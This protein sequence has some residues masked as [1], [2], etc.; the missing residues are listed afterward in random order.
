[1][2]RVKCLESYNE[3]SSRLIKSTVI[4]L[5]AFVFVA[6]ISACTNL[7][8]SEKLKESPEN[9]QRPQ[10]VKTDLDQDEK[11]AKQTSLIEMAERTLV[12]FISL[13]P[14]LQQKIDKAYGYA[15]FDSHMFNL[16]LYVAGK[17]NGI[18]I[19]NSSKA[20]IYM[21]MLRAGTGPGVG[22][23]KMRQ[24]LIIKNEE[25]FDYLTTIG[26][27]VQ[28]STHVVLKVGD[29]GGSLIYA[30]SFNPFIEVYTLID[31][32]IDIQANWGAV[33]YLKDWDLNETSKETN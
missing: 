21:L 29:F 17:G 11:E 5:A 25:T 8:T 3:V 20:P 33:E 14:E 23:T 16:I 4:L 10:A 30:E 9:S 7:E 26:L 19:K 28:V 22:Y 32:G 1:M 27:D 31:K 24:L 13:E 18:A 15:V 2:R 6:Q 12:D